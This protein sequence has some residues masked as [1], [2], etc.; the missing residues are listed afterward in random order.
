[1]TIIVIITL[2]FA[3]IATGRAVTESDHSAKQEQP[4]PGREETP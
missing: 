2:L 3:G 1:M 4:A